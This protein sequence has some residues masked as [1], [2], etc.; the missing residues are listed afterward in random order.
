MDM[1]LSTEHLVLLDTPDQPEVKSISVT[2]GPSGYY[3]QSMWRALGSTTVRQMN[4]PATSQCL[5]RKVVHL[6]GDS[7]IRQWFEF[8][9][10]TL[11][12]LKQFDL[13]VGKEVGPFMAV[14]HANNILLKFRFHGPPIILINV[15]SSELRY[16]T[17]ELDELTGGANA[18]VVIGVW[19]HFTCFPMEVYIRRLLSI[20]RAV[21]RLL[22]RAPRTTVI[23]RTGNPRS[24]TLY[25]SL[26][27]SDW[28]SMQ[29]NKVLRDVFKG[30]NVHWI[31]AWEMVLAH[32]LPHDL[33]PPTPIISNMID[34]LLSHICPKKD[35]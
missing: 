7:T 28:Y 4:M 15:P 32:H 33:H 11:P 5:K 24:L 26:I 34:V 17:N 35:G 12:D 30:L 29:R 2:S 14:D 27:H 10:K 20:R 3:Y 22:D 31:D 9:M 6:Y 23:I 25:Y 8:F 18:V 16:I 19:A 21:V 13:H 1:S